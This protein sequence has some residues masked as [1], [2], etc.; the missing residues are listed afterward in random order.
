MLC[1]GDVVAQIPLQNEILAKSDVC[2]SIL[3]GQQN[4]RWHQT[5]VYDIEKFTVVMW[6]KMTVCVHCAACR[7]TV[8]LH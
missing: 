3:A 1:S 2:L 6:K 8:F 5:N 4:C 7:E